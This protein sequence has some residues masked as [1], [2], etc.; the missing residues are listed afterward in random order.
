MKQ[1]YND[2]AFIG[3]LGIGI[4]VCSF[5]AWQ[6]C[7]YGG[8]LAFL[9]ARMKAE[10]E[11]MSEVNYHKKQ[12]RRWRELVLKR[13]GGLCEECKRYGRVDEDGLPP[14]ATI[15]H[16]IKHADEYPELRYVVSNGEALCAKCHNKM[17]P[18]KGKGFSDS[19]Y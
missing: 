10:V 6:A 14:K 18:E 15:A 5:C 7:F 2:S 4:C 19:F 12:H 8:T 3:S 16:H 1:D 9:L 13:A 11:A 17:H